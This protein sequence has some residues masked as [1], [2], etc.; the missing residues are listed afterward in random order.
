MVKTNTNIFQQISQIIKKRDIKD[1]TTLTEIRN[2]TIAY[3]QNGELLPLIYME[4]FEN[5]CDTSIEPDP[6]ITQLI[7]QYENKFSKS[8]AKRKL[9]LAPMLFSLA[10]LNGHA[11]EGLKEFIKQTF[12]INLHKYA[13][14]EYTKIIQHYLMHVH[15]NEELFFET[16]KEMLDPTF[17]FAHN[18]EE[19]K[20]LL[21]NTLQILWNNPVLFNNKKWLSIFEDGVALLRECRKQNLIEEHMHLHFFL[22]HIYGNNIQTIDEWRRFNEFIEKPAS[23]FYSEYGKEKNLP[24][25]KVHIAQGKKRIGI[26]ID[27]IVLNSPYM[28]LYSL[29]DNL[30]ADKNFT[31]EYELFLYS[32]NYIDKHFDQENLIKDLVSLGIR[33]YT[34]FEKFKKDGYY[35]SHY[36]KSDRYPKPNH[37]RSNRLSH[38]KRRI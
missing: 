20:S 14:L 3:L 2:K 12:A 26:L 30:V 35:Y 22:Y 4:L 19:R 8:S 10:I 13:N 25:P 9:I 6:Y 17:F 31:K 34:P 32:M 29:L 5:F 1:S 23:K 21:I 11:K 7:Q 16:I 36:R 38:S 18:L 15:A 27:R 33:V 24:K 28:V 37:S